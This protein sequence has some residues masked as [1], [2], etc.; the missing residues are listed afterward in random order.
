MVE[1]GSRIADIGT[2]HAYLPIEL[3]RTHR[4][5]YALAM[6]IRPGPLAGAR[7]H[8]EAAGLS[9][10]IELRLSNGL[11]AMRPGEA[12]T[13]ILA[14]MGGDLIAQILTDGRKKLSGV[15]TLLLSPHTKVA[16]VRGLLDELDFQIAREDMVRDAGKYYVILCAK[17]IQAGQ[18]GWPGGTGQDGHPVQAG[19]DGCPTENDS[20]YEAV[21]HYCGTYL[22]EHA[23][24]LL[25]EWLLKREET[26]WRICTGLQEKDADAK[27]LQALAQ[28]LELIRY[29]L[30][31]YYAS[32]E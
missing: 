31:H 5:T 15:R 26:L 32:G 9:G 18:D 17:R 30:A 16:R 2:D 27:R 19:P 10:Q 12:D 22:P 23:H 25:R 24:P 8:A 7:E 11:S 20:L 28:E 4:V 6:D 14:G 1:E 21:R 29:V 13:V 3:V